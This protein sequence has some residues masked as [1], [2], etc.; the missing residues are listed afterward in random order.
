MLQVK[1]PTLRYAIIVRE[2][3]VTCCSPKT[4]KRKRMSG[5]KTTI[6]HFLI[7]FFFFLIHTCFLITQNQYELD[8]N[9]LN[10]VTDLNG[11]FV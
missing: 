11:K 1:S 7:I 6:I 10:N 8:T 2:I 3:L 4:G 9:T 5:D